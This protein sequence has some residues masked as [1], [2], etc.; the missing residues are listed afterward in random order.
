MTRTNDVQQDFRP[1]SR[2]GSMIMPL[3][4]FSKKSYLVTNGDIEDLLEDENSFI[5]GKNPN[6]HKVPIY[7]IVKICNLVDED[8][9]KIRRRNDNIFIQQ[10]SPKGRYIPISFNENQ[11]N[12]TVR[13]SSRRLFPIFKRTKRSGVIAGAASP[14]AAAT[15]PQPVVTTTPAVGDF[16]ANLVDNVKFTAADEIQGELLDNSIDGSQQRVAA[17]GAGLRVGVRLGPEILAT[18]N[19]G[20]ATNSNDNN[21]PIPAFHVTYGCFILIVKGNGCDIGS[22]VGDWEHMTLFFGGGTGPGSDPGRYEPDS[23]YVSA[24][25]AGAYYNYNRLTGAFEFQRQET[26]KGILQRPNFPKTVTTYNNHPVLFAAKGSHG[27]WTAPGKHRF[28]KVARLYDINGFGTPWHTWKS[29]EIAYE[30]LVLVCIFH[31]HF[32]LFKIAQ[33]LCRLICRV[34]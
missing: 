16:I 5:Y 15:V 8:D 2:R 31:F 24:H 13:R 17:A 1:K 28:V 12:S 10:P 30:N 14:A 32:I 19:P 26:R 3:G 20:A 25:D 21:V 29:V 9:E 18:T 33:F 11:G 23:M 6:K 4:E 22:H 34:R 27:L 7:A